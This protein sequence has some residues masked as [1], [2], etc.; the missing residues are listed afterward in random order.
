[1]TIRAREPLISITAPF[2]VFGEYYREV[3]EKN[4]DMVVLVL[5]SGITRRST[6]T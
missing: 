2:Q 6:V 5:T 3:S 1:M 4:S